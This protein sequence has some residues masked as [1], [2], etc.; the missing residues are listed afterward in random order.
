[1]V[2]DMTQDVRSHLARSAGRPHAASIGR[3]DGNS[4][5][6]TFSDDLTRVPLRHIIPAQPGTVSIP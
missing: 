4:G 1:M 3:Q 5:Q 6:E 2:S